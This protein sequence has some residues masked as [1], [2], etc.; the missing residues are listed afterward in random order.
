M[1]E[2]TRAAWTPQEVLDAA[3]TAAASLQSLRNRVC[4]VIGA[5]GDLG[6]SAA[7][8]LAALGAT[9]VAAGRNIERA[10]DVARLARSIGS[11][12]T[13]FQVDVTDRTSVSELFLAV[14]DAHGTLDVLVNSAGTNVRK[15]AENLS[16]DEWDAILTTNLTGAFY[17][18]QEAFRLMRRQSRGRMINIGSA[19]GLVARASPPTSAYGTSKAGLTHMTRYLAAEWAPYG[20]TVNALA[21]GY[22]RTELTRPLWSDPEKMARALE[23]TP[24]DRLGE[25]AEFISPLTFLASDGSSFITGHTLS[26][27]GGRAVL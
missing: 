10:E 17:A 2:E 26:V 25:L 18:C 4:L 11:D 23:L 1:S 9:V 27:D 16:A 22:F 13:S 21:P 12:A 19:A 5:S 8:G 7:L 6:R 14:E 20:I 3:R 15:P 24:M